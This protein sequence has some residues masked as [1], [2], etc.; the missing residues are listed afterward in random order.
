MTNMLN[1]I[2][3][4]VSMAIPEG[5]TNQQITNLATAIYLQFFRHHEAHCYQIDREHTTLTVIPVN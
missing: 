4:G 1:K 5:Y 3:D 2:D